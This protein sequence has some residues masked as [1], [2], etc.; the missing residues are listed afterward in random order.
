MCGVTGDHSSVWQALLLLHTSQTDAR[1][2]KEK[3]GA[4]VRTRCHQWIPSAIQLENKIVML[5]S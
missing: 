2:K 4:V 5:L 1:M 3:E